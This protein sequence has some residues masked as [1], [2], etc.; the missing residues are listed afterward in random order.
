MEGSGQ[1]NRHQLDPKGG[2]EW[3]RQSSPLDPK[4][5]E[6]SGEDGGVMVNKKSVTSG[7]FFDHHEWISPM[8]VT[9]D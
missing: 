9:K 8:R 7:A 4:G 5:E 3:T 6:G 2:V 1:D